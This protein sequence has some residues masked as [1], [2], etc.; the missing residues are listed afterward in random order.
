M[1][2]AM[3]VKLL[4]ALQDRRVRPLGSD[5]E[6][7]FEA[8]L[9]AATHRD[10]EAEVAA[11]RFRQDLFFRIDVIEV[12][13]PPL[14]A[15]G[16]DILM[17]ASAFVQRH[18]TRSG[19]PALHLARAAAERLLAYDWPGNVRELENCIERAAALAG[20]DEIGAD[21]LPERIRRAT[22]GSVLISATA[23][24]ELVTLDEMERRYILRVLHAVGGNKKLAAQILSLDRSTLYRKLERYD[25]SP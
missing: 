16:G 25:T 17:L 7:P 3:Q 18:A 6:V 4:R 1:P 11:G 22:Q 21:D 2:L 5:R 19:R 20:S 24:D 8:R 12:M 14:R 9:V 15:R 10:L 23:A 13:L